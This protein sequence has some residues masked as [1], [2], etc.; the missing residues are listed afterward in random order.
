VLNEEKDVIF[1]RTDKPVKFDHCNCCYLWLYNI[2]SITTKSK[3]PV[4]DWLVE[5]IQPG[6]FK[7]IFP[8]TN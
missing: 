2:Y 3:I 4:F 5:S 6:E 7:S 8:V 1:E